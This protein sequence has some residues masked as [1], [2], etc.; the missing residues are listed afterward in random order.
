MS[1]QLKEE[2]NIWI[3]FLIN[4]S[5]FFGKKSIKFA[6]GKYLYFGGRRVLF[7][8]KEAHQ[9]KN[10][11]LNSLDDVIIP[12]SMTCPISEQNK[13]ASKTIIKYTAVSST[14]KSL[15]R[16]WLCAHLCRNHTFLACTA[17]SNVM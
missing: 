2:K 8:C 1:F 17:Q 6:V 12:E 9:W 16:V 14:G 3:S 7:H 10:Y 15:S 4:L 11:T 5:L 13:L